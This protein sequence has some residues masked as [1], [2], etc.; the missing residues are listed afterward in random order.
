[1]GFKVLLGK[2]VASDQKFGAVISGIGKD[3]FF[4]GKKI[5]YAIVPGMIAFNSIC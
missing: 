4:C 5:Y 3:S 1:M 2:Y